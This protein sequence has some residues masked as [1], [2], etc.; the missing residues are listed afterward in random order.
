MGTQQAGARRRTPKQKNIA[1]TCMCDQTKMSIDKQTNHEDDGKR[2][3]NV[4]V[5]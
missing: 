1:D 4:Q 2:M 5:K 3:K